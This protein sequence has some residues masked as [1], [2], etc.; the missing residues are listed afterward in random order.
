MKQH[1]RGVW[2]SSLAVG[3]AE[4]AAVACI[5]ETKA[6]AA[7]GIVEMKTGIAV[8]VGAAMTVDVVSRVELKAAAAAAAAAA[9]IGAART[10]AVAS[11][12]ELK[13]AAA[14]GVETTKTVAVASRVVLKKAAAAAAAASVE[15]TK[16]ADV[17][18]VLLD[19]LRPHAGTGDTGPEQHATDFVA[20]RVVA[21]VIGE[22]GFVAIRVAIR[23]AEV[24][25]QVGNT[26]PQTDMPD[27]DLDMKGFESDPGRRCTVEY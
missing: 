14:A 3:E 15:T 9:G 2:Q 19:I 4:T 20:Q 5:V 16:T 26:V 17:A 13:A 12:V 22:F 21:G 25:L 8:L 23:G 27:S 1:C 18:G 11:R 10:V 6:A 24:D 7:V